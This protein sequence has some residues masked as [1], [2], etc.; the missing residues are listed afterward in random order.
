MAYTASSSLFG[1][2][3]ESYPRF[4]RMVPITEEVAGAYVALVK[5]LNWNRVAIISYDNDEYYLNVCMQTQLH[6]L[7]YF[8]CAYKCDKI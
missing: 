6:I 1:I 2:D 3:K 4:Y 5:E 8:A 7:F